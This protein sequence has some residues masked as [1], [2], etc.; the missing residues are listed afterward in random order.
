MQCVFLLEGE[1]VKIVCDMNNSSNR[2]LTPQVK[3]RRKQQFFTRNKSNRRLICQTLTS[4][5]GDPIIG[6][7]PE[8]HAEYSLQIPATAGCTISNC[9][10][11]EVEYVIEVGR[12]H[13]WSDVTFPLSLCYCFGSFIPSVKSR[14]GESCVLK[15]QC[16][17]F[18]CCF[19]SPYR[20]TWR[21]RAPPKSQCCFPSSCLLH[22]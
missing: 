19:V 3:L 17:V 6:P 8:V 20:W 5:T 9:S 15:F 18:R 12:T 7:N 2:R 10:I 21:C 4:M 14:P 1:T 16:F 11:L 13:W 22:L